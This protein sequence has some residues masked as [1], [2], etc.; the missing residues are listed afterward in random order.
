[1]RQPAPPSLIG[2]EGGIPSTDLE[3]RSLAIA[4][5]VLEGENYQ[6]LRPL[7][8]VLHLANNTSDNI[9]KFYEMN[10]KIRLWVM[11]A[12]LQYGDVQRRAE[13]M[14][15]FIKTALVSPRNGLH[16]CNALKTLFQECCEMRDIFSSTAIISAL[17]S[18]A[19][20][21]LTLTTKS[22]TC[23]KRK[24]LHKLYLDS[25][26]RDTLKSTPTTG[27]TGIPW[28][29]VDLN[30]L[31]KTLSEH[32]VTIEEEG[33]HLI[34]LKRYIAFMKRST[35]LLH[36]MPPFGGDHNQ[37]E[38]LECLLAQLRTITYPQDTDK[39]LLARSATL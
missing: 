36:D 15:Y 19:I 26:Y 1:M 9:N 37:R 33:R 5:S 16:L 17:D 3:P 24:K 12:I 4:L 2:Q 25:K 39:R 28:L 18:A 29:K 27:K 35:E 6:A 30:E 21:G 13:I 10:D 22:L 8:Y 11:K 32:P 7:D 34:N 31:E 14:T 23:N 38:K 20:R